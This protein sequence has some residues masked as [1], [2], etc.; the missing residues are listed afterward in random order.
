MEKGWGDIPIG[1]RFSGEWHIPTACEW[2][3]DWA[4]PMRHQWMGG[5]NWGVPMDME[6][7]EAAGM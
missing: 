1:L 3:G 5:E 2:W 7:A 4:V 6:V